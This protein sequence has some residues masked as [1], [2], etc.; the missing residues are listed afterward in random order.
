D[1][2][3][4]DYRDATAELPDPVV[5]AIERFAGVLPAG[6]RVLEVGS[7]GGR[8]A[9]AWEGA[10]LDVRR[11]DVT[12][13]F[14]E[15]LRTGGEEADLLDPLTDDLADPAAPGTPYAGVW[16]N[17]CLLHVRREDLPTALGRLADESA[18]RRQL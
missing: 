15:L 13:G 18:R 8:A 5:S 12:P 3:A 14:V 11:T 7:G 1:A 10:G 16:A 6:A 2:S 9:G 4:A 17:A